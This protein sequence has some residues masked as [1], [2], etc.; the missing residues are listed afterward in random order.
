MDWK[1]LAATLSIPILV[2]S[3]PSESLAQASVPRGDT[4]TSRSRPALD[5]LGVR[6]GA[7]LFFPNLFIDQTYSDN[8]F[9][10]EN[11]TE[12]DFITEV[13]PEFS[14]ES[15]WN[16]HALRLAAG[17]NFGLY[18]DNDAEDFIDYFTSVDGRLDI[19]RDAA[20]FAN[21]G[22]ARR[23]E[24]RGDPDD[25]RGRNPTEFD[26]IDG[27]LRY[28][29]SF[30]RFRTTTRAE[31]LRLDFENVEAA[32]PG[33]AQTIQ[34]DRDRS[35]F[36]GG[37]RVGY[38]ILPSY[39]AF[40]QG[41]GNRRN[42]DETDADDAIGTDRDSYGYDIVTGVALDLGGLLFGE[43]FVGFREQTYEEGSLNDN[44]GVTFGTTIDWN[45]T[46]LT[47]FTFRV[48]QDVNDTTIE[49]AS[50][51]TVTEGRF[52]V[53]HELLRN[54]LLNGNVSVSSNDYEGTSRQDYVFGTG[55]GARYLMNRNFYASIGYR[56]VRRSSEDAVG[57]GTPG[58]DPDFS[59]N[60]FRIGLEAQL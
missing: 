34:N 37:L 13:R 16:N 25:V 18:A 52:G 24:E 53:D 12:A 21:G 39:E 2:L 41:T 30:G 33:S 54:L 46:P 6:L 8:I 60:R 11:D 59:E 56:F 36:T 27:G 58:E 47:T 35:I 9:A 10:S 55:I 3:T 40:I 28:V 19:T 7:F 14:L 48:E 17:S 4:V 20:L 42:Y 15:D 50:G 29:H 1:F 26:L 49:G 5:P 57:D 38:E 44:S 51:V 31:F 43:V 23:H 32:G 22:Y 45:V